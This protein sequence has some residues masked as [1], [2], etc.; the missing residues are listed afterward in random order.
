MSI[1]LFHLRRKLKE[2]GAPFQ[3]LEQIRDGGK[4]IQV[5]QRKIECIFSGLPYRPALPA[6]QHRKL[7]SVKIKLE[8]REQ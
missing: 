4:R 2:N 5:M 6:T 3:L 7:E 8:I 1:A